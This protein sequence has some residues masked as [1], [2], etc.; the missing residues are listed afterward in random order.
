M[1]GQSK[2]EQIITLNNS[3][4]SLN[5]VLV[6]TRANA[7]KDIDGL[8]SEIAQLKSDVSSLESSMAKLTKENDKFKLDL[9]EL[10]QKN[11]ALEAKLSNKVKT[12]KTF[13]IGNLEVMTEDLDL[14]TNNLANASNNWDRAKKACADLGGGWRLPTIDE[15]N[16]LYENKD[17][18]GGFFNVYYW[19]STEDVSDRMWVQDLNNNNGVQIRSWEKYLSG[20]VRAVRAF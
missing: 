10:S 8:N 6:T 16:V 15:L 7:T 11:L 4:D 19:S 14:N 1:F 18:I 9:K 3:I 5:T 20:S 17:K 13:K 2:K 12:F